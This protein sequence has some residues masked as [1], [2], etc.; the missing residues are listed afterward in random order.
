MA[1]SDP[2]AL[3]IFIDGSAVEVFTGCGQVLTTRV[4]RGHPGITQGP[5]CAALAPSSQE[6]ARAAADTDPPSCSS[7]KLQLRAVGGQCVVQHAEVFECRSCWLRG[8]DTPLPPPCSPSAFEH[9]KQVVRSWKE[10]DPSSQSM[11][12]AATSKGS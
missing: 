6:E 1:D 8:D 5:E 10:A 11:G 2:L 12:P 7:T 9:W 4:Y 3:R